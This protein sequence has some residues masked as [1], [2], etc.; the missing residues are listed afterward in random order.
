MN[1]IV[2]TILLL[3]PLF[4]K[5]QVDVLRER[6]EKRNFSEYEKLDKL[7]GTS[8]QKTYNRIY[9]DR[10]FKIEV[11]TSKNIITNETYSGLIIELNYVLDYWT[12]PFAISRKV[13]LDKYEVEKL[14]S[15]YEYIIDNI[16]NTVPRDY[17]EVSFNSLTSF[18]SG[19]F[20]DNGYWRGYFQ[21]RDYDDRSFYSMP[22]SEF[23]KLYN[24]I[25][26]AYS[27]M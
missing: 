14:L 24:D 26:S 9:K 22:K 11:V 13:V 6:E 20:W 23:I 25:K 21:I 8:I 2:I 5:S 18:R 19:V 10:D 4:A 3:L 16:L 1:R 17:T 27:K 7:S 15:T 12:K